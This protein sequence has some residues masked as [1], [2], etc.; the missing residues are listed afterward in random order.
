MC[1]WERLPTVDF[2]SLSPVYID[3]L[4]R[5]KERLQSDF[6][7]L[8]QDHENLEERHQRFIIQ[9]GHDGSEAQK[10]RGHIGDNLD[11][12]CDTGSFMVMLCP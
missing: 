11:S 1:R 3:R 8:K 4:S 7:H 10:G 2:L 5:E 9:Y 6:D 12:S